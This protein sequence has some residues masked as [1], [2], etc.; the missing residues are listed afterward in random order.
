MPAQC[1]GC[2][3]KFCLAHHRHE[4]HGCHVKP[5]DDRYAPVC[6][7][8]MQAIAVK[9]GDNL[10]TVVDAHIRAGCPT[11]STK[12]RKNACSFKGCREKEFMPIS[13]KLCK[14]PFCLKHR[15]ESDHD[16]PLRKGGAATAA[17]NAAA[18]NAVVAQK[19]TQQAQQQ[20]QQRQARGQ[21]VP[22]T[23]GDAELARR[24][25]GMNSSVRG[26]SDS[27][28]QAAAGA[29]SAATISPFSPFQGLGSSQPAAGRASGAGGG[30]P[31]GGGRRQQKHTNKPENA[32]GA[33]GIPDI[34]RMLLSVYFPASSNRAPEFH[35]LSARWSVGKVI[36]TLAERG[37]IRNNNNMPGA[38]RLNLFNRSA[39]R[40]DTAIS[41]E[42]L[43]LADK[44]GGGDVVILE[45]AETLSRHDP[46]LYLT[47]KDKSGKD[48]VLM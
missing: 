20:Q 43:V 21:A 11:A 5:R 38:T 15:F 24:L 29:W 17:A 42:S 41:L 25:A 9:P 33:H 19:R 39:A 27:L 40:L 13:C 34:E 48:C 37:S 35:V 6:P 16:C 31:A 14:R 18:A 23:S 32:K 8:C 44:L 12:S 10:N 26:A 47:A 36:D 3:Q 1:D 7:L 28:S 46:K 30:G 4:N 45:Y 2:G 22:D